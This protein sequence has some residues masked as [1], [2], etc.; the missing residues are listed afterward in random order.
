MSL[1]CTVGQNAE[2]PRRTKL[3]PT[4]LLNTVARIAYYGFYRFMCIYIYIYIYI[5][6]YI[7]IYT[8]VYI[9]MYIYVYVYICIICIYAYTHVHTHTY[10]YIYIQLLINNFSDD[11]IPSA[12]QSAAAG[13]AMNGATVH[14]GEN[15]TS[16]KI[17]MRSFWYDNPGHSGFNSR[18]NP[19]FGISANGAGQSSGVEHQTRGAYRRIPVLSPSLPRP[20]CSR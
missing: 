2:R 9:Y 20:S 8:Y 19:S 14:T 12:E 17:D 16:L 6:T 13:R 4:S 3:E 7:C 1:C 5:H 11:K 10:I 18:R 15:Y